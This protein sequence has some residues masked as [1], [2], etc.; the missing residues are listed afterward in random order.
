MF[1][2]GFKSD[3]ETLAS[4][5]SDQL[6]ELDVVLITPEVADV[7]GGA[8]LALVVGQDDQGIAG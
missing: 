2:D 3:A 8:D 6:G 4:D 1:E 5:L 7:A